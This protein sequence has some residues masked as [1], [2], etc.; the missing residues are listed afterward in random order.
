M[1]APVLAPAFSERVQHAV[2]ASYVG[3]AGQLLRRC[4]GCSATDHGAPVVQPD[5]VRFSVSH[6]AAFIAVA[7]VASPKPVGIDLEERGRTW[8]LSSRTIQRVLSPAERRALRASVDEDEC[9]L[10]MWTRKEAIIKSGDR[11]LATVAKIDS[12]A[13]GHGSSE[14]GDAVTCR[15]IL[16]DNFVVSLAVDDDCRLLHP[17]DLTIP[18]LTAVRVSGLQ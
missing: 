5:D 2:V 3:S 9:F 7:V 16:H 8:S 15:T 6:S 11:R 10:S 17:T 1:T 12:L 4:P 14:R 18:G 13:H